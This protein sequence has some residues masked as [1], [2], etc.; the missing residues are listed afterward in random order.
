MNDDLAEIRERLDS[1]T[2]RRRTYHVT[3]QAGRVL[4]E[5]LPTRPLIR[6]LVRIRRPAG[7]QRPALASGL[8]ADELPAR[9]ALPRRRAARM[10]ERRTLNAAPASP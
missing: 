9:L 6:H 8:R 3:T 1:L 4:E 2:Q 5:D 10:S 7:A